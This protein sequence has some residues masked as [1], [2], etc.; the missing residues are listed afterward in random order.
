MSKKQIDKHINRGARLLDLGRL[1][2]SMTQSCLA[3]KLD[4]RSVLA[5]YNLGSALQGLGRHQEA[6][7][8]F[9][10]AM[11][12]DPGFSDPRW[13]QSLSLLMLGDYKAGFAGYQARFGKAWGKTT[14]IV[15]MPAALAHIPF[16]DGEDI[17]G[18]NLLIW[19]EQ[20][21]GDIIM[22]LRYL[23]FLDGQG[24]KSI[25]LRIPPSL[26]RLVQEMP[27]DVRITSTDEPCDLSGVDYHCPLLS[28]PY[29]FGTTL[30]TIPRAPYMTVPDEL[31]DEVARRRGPTDK[32]KVGLAWA[33]KKTL[34][35]DHLRSMS[36]STIAPLT[37][38]PGIACFS[39]QKDRNNFM[40]GGPICDLMGGCEDFMDTAALIMGLDLV[41]AVDTSVAHLAGALG[42]PV[43]LLNRFESEWRWG[44]EDNRSPWYPSMR[45][46]RQTTP[47][48]WDSV[49]ETVAGLLPRFLL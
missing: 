6:I 23:P 39:L 32:F 48:D 12:L 33:G 43:W 35:K 41:I 9:Q 3:L 46:F 18:K 21:L 38:I 30:D 8:C 15:P 27:Y 31:V 17:N 5:A 49:I 26:L 2:E 34:V 19:V 24:A 28:L 25:M 37:E 16:W 36:Y 44:L 40:A 7:A 10:R 14:S 13:N 47:G 29:V 20:G 1:D 11:N 42:K 45:I 4:P 22:M